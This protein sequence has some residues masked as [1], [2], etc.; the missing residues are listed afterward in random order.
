[1]K[2]KP[3]G[4]TQAPKP[5]S[6]PGIV[7]WNVDD[8][9]Q[10]AI[11]Q[12]LVSP[13]QIG[14]VIPLHH[15]TAKFKCTTLPLVLCTHP[16]NQSLSVR[17]SS[18]T[19]R[20][21]HPLI[22]PSYHPFTHT[23]FPPSFSLGPRCVYH[24]PVFGVHTDRL[25]LLGLW[26]Y[27]QKH[28]VV[29]PVH[30]SPLVLFAV[31]SHRLLSFSVLRTERLSARR[32]PPFGLPSSLHSRPGAQVTPIPPPP[33]PITSGDHGVVQHTAVRWSKC[34]QCRGGGGGLHCFWPL[35][36]ARPRKACT[37]V[38]K[39]V[40]GMTMTTLIMPVSPPTLHHQGIPYRMPQQPVLLWTLHAP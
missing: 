40:V 11:F 34:C 26:I 7:L 5:Y 36:L 22:H 2:D 23:A 14:P 24:L 15:H 25:V 28:S 3:K 38:S 35:G 27:G 32:V 16:Q 9:R 6:Q 37:R 13:T 29:V 20:R 17:L 8:A 39:R 19:S 18:A 30:R 12:F 4:S 33:L 31:L 1:M 21:L 10:G